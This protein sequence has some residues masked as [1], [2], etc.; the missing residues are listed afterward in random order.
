MGAASGDWSPDALLTAGEQWANPPVNTESERG[1]SVCVGK[2][3]ADGC[4]FD[5]DFVSGCR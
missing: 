4:R 3:R 2:D 1:T 5:L